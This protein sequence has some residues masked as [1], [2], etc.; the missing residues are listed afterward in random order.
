[1][2]EWKMSEH[3]SLDFKMARILNKMNS[4]VRIR[5]KELVHE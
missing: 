5:E 2:T 1:M 4:W 3:D